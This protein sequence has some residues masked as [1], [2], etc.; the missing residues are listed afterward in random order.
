MLMPFFPCIG[1]APLISIG[2]MSCEMLKLQ[3]AA[4]LGKADTERG[5][6]GKAGGMAVVFVGRPK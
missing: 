3:L 4:L 2:F 5:C 6:T 1:L